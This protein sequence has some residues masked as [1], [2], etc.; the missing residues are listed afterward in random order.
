MNIINDALLIFI[1]IIHLI[2]I[3]FVLAA[4]FSN[5]NYLL[6]LHIIVVPFIVLHWVLN[7]N[8]CCLTVMERYIRESTMGTKINKEDCFTYQIVA[9]IYDFSKEH[10]TFATLIYILTISVWLISV[11]NFSYKICDGQ[12]KTLEDMTHI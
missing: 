6:L 3:I 11:Y 4:P 5:S 10:E 12:I 9:P 8:T 1:N 7:N 2:V